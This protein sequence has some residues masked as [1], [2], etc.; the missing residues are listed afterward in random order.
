MGLIMPVGN[1]NGNWERLFKVALVTMP[2]VLSSLLALN[3]W[4]V[5]EAFAS[6]AFRQSGERF[7]KQDAR[8]LEIRVFENQG[9]IRHIIEDLDEIKSLVKEVK[10]EL[11]GR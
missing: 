8:E 4:L 1:L 11:K 9:N 10:T 3:I 5:G 7:S 2:I 6:R